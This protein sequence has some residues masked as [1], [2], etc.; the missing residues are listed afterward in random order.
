M[1]GKESFYR[2]HF[3]LI[4]PAFQNKNS[5]FLS[6]KITIFLNFKFAYYYSKQLLTNTF[7]AFPLNSSPE[8][9]ETQSDRNYLIVGNR[10][11]GQAIGNR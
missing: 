6:K 4:N 3:H 1:N 7:L 8:S 2:Q 5:N 11:L 10:G 9:E